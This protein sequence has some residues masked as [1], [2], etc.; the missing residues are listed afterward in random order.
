MLPAARS[1]RRAAPLPERGQTLRKR[2]HTMPAVAPAIARTEAPERPSE[3]QRQQ[4]ARL[5]ELGV[6]SPDELGAAPWA[7]SADLEPTPEVAPQDLDE[8]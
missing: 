3:R 6:R 2:L 8:Q 4:S 5:A 1:A 7:R